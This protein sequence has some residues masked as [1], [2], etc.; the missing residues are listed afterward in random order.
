MSEMKTTHTKHETDPRPIT[1]L[2][3]RA[4]FERLEAERRKI[5]DA[6]GFR[7]SISAAA[8]RAMQRGLEA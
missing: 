2:L 4:Q 3:S 5:A 8:A 7:V 6:T 1:V